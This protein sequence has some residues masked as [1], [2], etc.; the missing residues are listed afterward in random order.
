MKPIVMLLGRSGRVPGGL[1]SPG[2]PSDDRTDR[3]DHGTFL[4]F[5][6]PGAPERPDHGEADLMA[7]LPSAER[8]L[9]VVP[10]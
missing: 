3:H 1:L 7:A 6:R 5:L 10:A 4:T 8:S 9:R 2:M